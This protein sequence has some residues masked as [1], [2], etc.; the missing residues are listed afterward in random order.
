[1]HIESHDR[2][3]ANRALAR[4]F[5]SQ[6]IDYTEQG[7]ILMLQLVSLTRYLANDKQHFDEGVQAVHETIDNLARALRGWDHAD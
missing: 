5:Q 4:W 7:R 1:M 6:D 3:Q 2:E